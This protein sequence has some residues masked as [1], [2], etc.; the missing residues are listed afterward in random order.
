M[1]TTKSFLTRSL[2]PDSYGQRMVSRLICRA[3]ASQPPCAPWPRGRGPSPSHRVQVLS[4]HESKPHCL[5]TVCSHVI[6]SCLVGMA[7]PSIAHFG[8]L[9]A[10][11]IFSVCR[12]S[13]ARHVL[14]GLFSSS[15]HG[16]Q[17]SCAPETSAGCLRAE[18]AR[19]GIVQRVA[20]SRRS[21]KSSAARRLLALLARS[22][23]KCNRVRNIAICTALEATTPVEDTLQTDNAGEFLS[24]E[25][26]EFLDSKLIHHTTARVLLT[27]TRSTVWPSEL[28]SRCP[29]SL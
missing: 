23:A 25:F 20:N 16:G 8:T 5:L 11:A 22:G 13:A 26:T 12:L 24:R 15:R 14:A 3:T 9:G 19:R 2:C 21:T 10:L 7:V 27:S 18:C 29:R 17:R 28:P 4:T 6:P 1:A